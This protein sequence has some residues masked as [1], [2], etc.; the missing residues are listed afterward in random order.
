MTDVLLTE[1][2]GRVALLVMNRPEARN[3][4]D[5]ALQQA[6]HAELEAIGRD[7]DVGAVVITGNGKGFCAGADLKDGGG[8]DK[9]MRSAARVVVH[10]FNPLIDSVT[11]M[12]KPVIAAVNGSA[13]GFGMSLALAC[14]LVVMSQDAF[15]LSNFI[16]VGL[17]PDGGATWLLQRR[18]G[19]GRAFELVADGKKLDAQRC[20]DYGLVNRVVA[21]DEVRA[22]ALEWAG[23]LAARA[24]MALALSKRLARLS[25][26]ANLPDAMAMEAEMQA[27]CLATEDS[28]EAIMAFVEKRDPK[29]TGR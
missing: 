9:T 26:S 8:G 29:F 4:I 15:M 25:Q 5:G 18:M 28:R 21:A 1:R 11:R 3:A 10:N 16:N 23:E 17:V 24:P 7:P 20:H 19:Y 6:L 14:D 13:A 2:K 27:L 22:T 12:D